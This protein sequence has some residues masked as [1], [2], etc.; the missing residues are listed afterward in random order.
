MAGMGKLFK[1]AQKM[2]KDMAKIQAEMASKTV[3]ATAGGG[4][5]TVVVNGNQ[6]VTNIKIEKEVVNSDD[7]EML[8]NL[9]IAAI[10]EGLRKSKEMV[11]DGMGKLTGGMN[12]PGLT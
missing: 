4:M 7:I 8:E 10:N 5:I 11:A 2:Q 1:Q 3:E 9:V 12:I 6:E